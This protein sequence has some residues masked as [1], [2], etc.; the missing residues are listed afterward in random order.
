MNGHEEEELVEREALQP[1]SAGRDPRAV[2]DERRRVLAHV[3]ALDDLPQRR[4][5]EARVGQVV[6]RE[7][8]AQ[9]LSGALYPFPLLARQRR[10]ARR[11]RRA[12]P[13]SAG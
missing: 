8:E 6:G 7:V 9:H 12:T 13:F 5:R 10:T 3:Q 2:D 1:P 4:A 11:A